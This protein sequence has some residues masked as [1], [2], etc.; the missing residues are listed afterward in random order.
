[1]ELIENSIFGKKDRFKIGDLVWWTE[2]KN[3][4]KKNLGVIHG[5]EKVEKGGRF[6]LMAKIYNIEKQQYIEILSSIL[7]KAEDNLR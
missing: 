7:H 3:I 2:I 5:F 6:L 1:M 4:A